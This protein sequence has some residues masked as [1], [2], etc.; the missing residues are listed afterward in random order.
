[1]THV[2]VSL[3]CFIMPWGRG[4]TG[5]QK[6]LKHG[7]VT[8]IRIVVLHLSL[9]VKVKLDKVKVPQKLKPKELKCPLVAGCN[10]DHKLRPQQCQVND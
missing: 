2:Y 6:L 8:Q 9:K 5:F 4:G 3:F 1:M 10:V 7:G